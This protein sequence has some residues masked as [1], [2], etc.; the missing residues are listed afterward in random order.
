MNFPVPQLRSVIQTIH[1]LE[2]WNATFRLA[3]V[4][5]ALF[6]HEVVRLEASPSHITQLHHGLVRGDGLHSRDLAVRGY[7]TRRGLALSH[8]TEEVWILVGPR[9]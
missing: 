3:D 2:T 9:R 4:D 5:F 1:G 8:Q 7:R 6:A